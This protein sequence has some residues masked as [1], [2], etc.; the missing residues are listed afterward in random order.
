[1]KNTEK[2]IKKWGIGFINMN[3]FTG[4]EVMNLYQP[5]NFCELGVDIAY[6]F[7]LFFFTVIFL[8]FS[9]ILQY[10]T[11][12]SPAPETFKIPY[13]VKLITFNFWQKLLA[14]FWAY[15]LYQS[16]LKKISIYLWS[17]VKKFS[18]SRFAFCVCDFKMV[19]SSY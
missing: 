19:I 10:G 18:N 9:I 4:S 2:S 11:K 12:S 7:P 15:T 13:L 5:S 8:G 1:M 6:L 14:V 3:S 17:L 16:F